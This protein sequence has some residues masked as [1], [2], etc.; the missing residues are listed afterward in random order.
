[1]GWF[2]VLRGECGWFRELECEGA[3]FFRD[4]PR[5]VE[6]LV[7]PEDA[8]PGEKVVVE[9]FEDGKA[10]DVLNPKKKVWEKLQVDL[11]VNSEGVA[12]WQNNNLL[13]KS[14]KK[15]HSKVVLNA[16]IK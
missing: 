15:I 14:G 6:P 3:S 2:C 13:T 4:E 10:D 12:Q 16:P 7:P 5:E 1:M 9:N 11:K 8:V